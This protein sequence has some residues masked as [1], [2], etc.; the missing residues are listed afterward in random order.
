MFMAL[1]AATSVTMLSAQAQRDTATQKNDMPTPKS[2][3]AAQKSNMAMSGDQHFVMETANASMAEVELGKLAQARGANP[4]VKAFG[5]QMVTDHSKANDELKQ[6]A[7]SKKITLP[8]AIDAAHKAVRDRLA[9]LSGAA[10]DKA[11]ADEMVK[12]HQ[13]VVAS[14][15]QEAEGGTDAEIKAWANK[16]L[17]TIEKHLQ[18]AQDLQKTVGPTT[19]NQ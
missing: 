15:K 12:G 1:V 18:Q 3:T 14:F 6:L 4:S 17:P 7:S 9:K 11:Y 19:S 5:Q 2:S 8:S 16:T 13:T 10:F